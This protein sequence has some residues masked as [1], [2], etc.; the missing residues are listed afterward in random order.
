M[1]NSSISSRTK[2]AAREDYGSL[3]TVD[4]D[5][6]DSPS[7]TSAT[8]NPPFSFP[9][10]S[11]PVLSNTSNA[12][13]GV[14][15]FAVPWGFGQAGLFGGIFILFIV[16][17]VSFE[18]ARA[19]LL[20]QRLLFQHTDRVYSYPEMAG[21]A[22]GPH[23]VSVVKCATVISC[24]GGNIGY[25]IFLGQ[26]SSQ[27]FGISFDRTV[28]FLC[29]PLTLLSWIRSFRDLTI[30]T[31][32]GV[33]AI[34]VSIFAII[35]D[36]TQSSN[37]LSWREDLDK[38]PLFL[39][40]TIFNMLGPST[41]M[42]TIHYCI[43]SMGQ[44]AL[45]ESRLTSD[46]S[47]VPQSI[48]DGDVEVDKSSTSPSSP[49]KERIVGADS[50][51]SLISRTFVTK[52]DSQSVMENMES[53]LLLSSGVGG[54]GGSPVSSSRSAGVYDNDGA[55]GNT[56]INS[57]ASFTIFVRS[58]AVS[59]IISTVLIGTLGVIAYLLF[60][61]SPIVT[62]VTG[63]VEPGCEDHVC[64]NI[65]LNLSQGRVKVVV[66]ASLFLAI[67]F[68]YILILA[69]AREHIERAVLYS[70]HP[71]K[72]SNI[73]HVRNFVRTFLV[74][75]TGAVAIRSPYFGYVLGMVGGLTDALQSFVLPPIIYFQVHKF[76]AKVSEGLVR[77]QG[78]INP[79]LEGTDK[80]NDDGTSLELTPYQSIAYRV[81]F[82]WGVATI[83]F[84]LSKI[85]M[86]VAASWIINSKVTST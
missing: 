61:S 66:E 18:T 82:V 69:P 78:S 62:T 9:A 6:V 49:S 17:Y 68:S 38:V 64:Q 74:I 14:S 41:F 20:V 24:I 26:I 37:A 28:C 19:M 8:Q 73:M 10:L 86:L 42:F 46:V 43:L 44:E 85:A 3:T 55:N 51:K 84:T 75:F 1:S 80:K 30:F 76:V 4:E 67:I 36:G 71:R 47:F 31:V 48:I 34:S 60:R 65:I 70:F 25:T 63:G 32:I 39:P 52:L 7:S 72:E 5:H 54:G 2:N 33:V 81:I 58:L 79:I 22:L 53:S 12:L 27:L 50:S 29:I 35:Y 11:V 40:S 77:K 45:K 83:A 57:K 16:S 56:N 15:I 59:Y 13:M 21:L 23:W